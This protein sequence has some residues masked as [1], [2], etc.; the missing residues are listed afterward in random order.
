MRKLASIAVTAGLLVTLSACSTPTGPFAG[1]EP[2]GNAELVTADGGFGNDPEAEFPTPLVAKRAELAIAHEGDGAEVS[3]D[4][5]VDVILSLYDAETGNPLQDQQGG[6]LTEIRIRTF[7]DGRF[8]FA[9][10]LSCAPVG[11]RVITTGTQTQLFGPEG[12]GLP[13]DTTLV[14]VSDIEKAYPGK[15][16]GADQ[17]PQA[18]YPSVVLAPDGRPGLTF[19]AGET[20]SELRHSVLKAGNGAKVETGDDLII[21]ITGIVWGAKTTFQSSWDS[22]APATMTLQEIDGSGNGFPPGLVEALTGQK[23]GSQI[24]AVVPPEHGFS[25]QA[26]AGVAEGDTLVFV[27]DILGIG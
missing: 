26:P 16:N 3:A 27:V 12:L 1:C 4:N 6:A 14:V 7:V 23:V 20:P 11:S 2:G 5:A 18:G 25:G 13:E 8:P 10:A 22:Q 9:V 15:A 17:L 24:I 19:P 21:N